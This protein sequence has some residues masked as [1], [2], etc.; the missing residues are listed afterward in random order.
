MENAME[1]SLSKVLTASMVCGMLMSAA[2]FAQ[3]T[4]P[5]NDAANAQVTSDGLYRLN[6]SVLERAWVKPGVDLSAY[7]KI[8][9]LPVGLT[10]K[11]VPRHS[12][13]SYPITDQQKQTLVDIVPEALGAE[14]GKMTSYQLTS[15]P[16]KGTLSVY[17]AVLDI[18]SYV[19]PEPVGRGATFVRTLGEATLVV[20]LRDSVTGEVVARAADR[21]AV[22]PAF[23]QRSNAVNN[24]VE[25]RNAARRWATDLRRQIDAFAHL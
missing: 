18:V 21:R 12:R 1:K 20:E 22:S 17:G 2:A 23:V 25:V 3:A 15:E 8:M 13:N 5:A 24:R 10:F 11:D 14:L 6:D 9:V 7:D 4:S 19:P 16:G